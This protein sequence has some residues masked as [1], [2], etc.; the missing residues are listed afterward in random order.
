M[1]QVEDKP[2]GTDAPNGDPNTGGISQFRTYLQIES[3][4]DYYEPSIYSVLTQFR[5][6]ESQ[7]DSLAGD[8][9]PLTP[10]GYQFG[11]SSRKGLLFAVGI[12]PPVMNISERM[13]DRSAS[14]ASMEGLGDMAV[15]LDLGPSVNATDKNRLGPDFWPEYVKM[16]NRLGVDPI[17][18]GDILTI[19][20]GFKPWKQNPSGASG[21]SQLMPYNYK[22][23]GMTDEEWE[24]YTKLSGTEQLYWIE[25]FFGG[26]VRGKTGAGLYRMNLGG[27]PN[28]D[29]SWY[30]TPE[31]AQEWLAQNPDHSIE[32]FET[33]Q[34]LSWQAKAVA[35][36]IGLSANRSPNYIDS[37]SVQAFLDSHPSGY[38][39]IIQAT[40]N[41]VGDDTGV[42]LGRP[43]TP[44][45]EEKKTPDW[46]T[47]GSGA[48]GSARESEDKTAPVNL[49]TSETGKRLQ[50]AQFKY[51]KI[52]QAALSAMKRMPPLRMLINPS[53]FT[54]SCEKVVQDGNRSRD[55]NIVEHWGDGQD[56]IDGSGKVA[57]FYSVDVNDSRVPGLARTIRN[58]SASYQN[59]LS[60]WLLYRNNG[61][62]WLPEGFASTKQKETNYLAALGSIYIYYDGVLYIGS[63][64]SFD[65]TESDD[66]PHTLEYSFSFTVRAWFLLDRQDEGEF[67]YGAAEFFRVS[68]KVSPPEAYTKRAADAMAVDEQR[69]AEAKKMRDEAAAND[70]AALLGLGDLGVQAAENPPVGGPRTA[71]GQ[72]PRGKA[73]GQSGARGKSPSKPSAPTNKA[74]PSPPPEPPPPGDPPVGATGYEFDA[75]GNVVGY[76]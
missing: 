57:G 3:S 52:A 74:E 2:T 9:V 53:Q 65:L 35:Q 18:M 58:W 54:V 75:D 43:Y 37:R 76:K 64:D 12:L 49:N 11:D 25:K 68:N 47:S 19:E 28:P 16:C 38:R 67:D 56:T 6:F 62:L 15:A 55:G 39:A 40:M 72:R 17:A 50:E 24:Y 45:K 51:V 5:T 61:G 70:P 36:N 14:I 60:L 29:G 22:S 27:C 10:S 41:Q 21:I 23:L 66:G 33:I 73:G 63:F 46:A 42:P 4:A 13:L 32:E 44:P 31:K 20:S 7:E 48:A 30:A 71:G 59:F 26:R 34:P 8:F 69:A 1:A